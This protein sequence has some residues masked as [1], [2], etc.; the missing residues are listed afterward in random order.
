[1]QPFYVQCL[2]EMF[3]PRGIHLVLTVQ[4]SSAHT[5]TPGTFEFG[6]YTV[7]NVLR[8]ISAICVYRYAQYVRAKSKIRLFQVTAVPFL[9]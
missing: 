8:R 6:S 4:I 2:S 9:L 3:I 5:C 7:I 1:M